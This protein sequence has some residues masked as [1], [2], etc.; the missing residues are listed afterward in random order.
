MITDLRNPS[1]KPRHW[2]LIE[3]VIKHKFDPDEPLTLSFLEELQV[4]DFAEAIQEISGQAS[5]EASLEA[6]LKKVRLR[7]ICLFVVVVFWQD[8]SVIKSMLQNLCCNEYEVHLQGTH[9]CRESIR[10]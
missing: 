4:F 9:R 1:L 7:S 2:S 5:S 3:E 8:E 10:T 6:I